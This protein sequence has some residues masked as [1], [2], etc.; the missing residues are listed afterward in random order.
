MSST[1]PGPRE[2]GL[3]FDDARGCKDW[4]GALPLTNIPQAQTLLHEGLR[5]LNAS[6]MA[7]L[8][9]LKCLE[10]MRDKIA[11][12]QGEIRAACLARSASPLAASVTAR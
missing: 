6:G 11:Y 1:P 9:R 4:L 3:A 7:G 10:T 2:G 12:L 8:E 5:G